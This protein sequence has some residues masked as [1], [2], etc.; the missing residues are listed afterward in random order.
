M[1]QWYLLNDKM[2]QDHTELE[3]PMVTD[4]QVETERQVTMDSVT[5][6]TSRQDHQVKCEYCN[7]YFGSIA[8]CNMQVNRRHK[9]VKCLSVK[10]VF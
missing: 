4:K 7:R 2:L 3:H 9:K 6:D 10:S 8:E 5:L 1:C